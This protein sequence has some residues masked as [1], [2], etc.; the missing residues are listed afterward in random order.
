MSTDDRR[1]LILEVLQAQGSVSVAELAQRTGVSAST[2]RR[3]LAE[4]E[5]MGLLRR[6]HGRAQALP[7]SPTAAVRPSLLPEQALAHERISQVAASLVRPGMSL[8]LDSGII[9]ERIAT[10]LKSLEGPLTVFTNSVPVALEIAASDHIVTLLTGGQLVHPT[11]TLTGYPAERTLEDI[12]AD[13]ALLCPDGVDLR[14][15]LFTNDLT[16]VTLR[17]TM[18][19]V[20]RRVVAIVPALQIDLPALANFAPI[21]GIHDIVT[22]SDLSGALQTELRTR[23]IELHLA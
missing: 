5:E 4:M 10:Q 1:A 3:D 7:E 8:V 14:R 16:S 22:T 2:I 13:M 9:A 21:T 20:V 19:N 15:G 6:T 18:V 12:A 23:G 11:L 17:R